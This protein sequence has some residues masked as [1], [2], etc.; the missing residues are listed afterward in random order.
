MQN[1]MSSKKALIFENGDADY[2]DIIKCLPEDVKP[3][4]R[5]KKTDKAFDGKDYCLC[6]C[7]LTKSEP[8]ANNIPLDDP[9]FLERDIGKSI[10]FIAK[11]RHHFSNCPVVIV[12]KLSVIWLRDY[13]DTLIRTKD[14]DIMRIFD[15]DCINVYQK[16]NASKRQPFGVVYDDK[17]VHIVIKPYSANNNE[18]DIEQ[19][20]KVFKEYLA[21]SVLT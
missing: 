16:L 21:N 18:D 5:K 14:A 12:T 15:N 7:D 19:W 6:I 17:K 3:L 20:K 11:L 1:N 2:E 8:I 13:F 4:R 9:L 10:K